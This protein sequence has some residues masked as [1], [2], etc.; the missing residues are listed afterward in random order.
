MVADEGCRVDDKFYAVLA[1]GCL[2]LHQPLKAA[3]VVR[4]AFHLP[5]HSLASPTERRTPPVGVEARALEE[6]AAKLRAGSAEEQKALAD[7]T[8]ELE[9]VRGIRLGDSHG[10][11]GRRD[12]PRRRGGG[13]GAGSGSGG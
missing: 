2:Q 9:E 5:G 4:A 13:N 7:L 8:T 1:R 10:S 3:E 12:V 11:G 6:V